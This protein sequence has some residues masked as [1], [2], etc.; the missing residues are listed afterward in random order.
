MVL[1]LL[2]SGLERPDMRT[3]LDNVLESKRGR[4]LVIPCAAPSG[5]GLNDTYKNI[6][7]AAGFDK[8]S[9]TAFDELAPNV[10]AQDSF[11]LFYVPGGNTFRLLMCLK[12]Y[13]LDKLIK[14]CVSKGAVYIGVSAGAYAACKEVTV[15]GY[16]DDDNIYDRDRSKYGALALT[17]HY[18]MCHYGPDR[19][20][21]L[22]EAE[23]LLNTRILTVTND[24]FLTIDDGDNC[25]Y[26]E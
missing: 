1:I 19:Y 3:R 17:E 21:Y 24:E 12:R 4:A 26:I 20:P 15:A 25:S 6:L 5:G 16:F 11:D 23:A 7:A 22:K 18:V 2:S 14:N 8:G 10:S 13:G 9:I